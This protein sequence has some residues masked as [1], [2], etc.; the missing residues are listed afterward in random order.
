MEGA[1]I[2]LA[3]LW[4]AYFAIHSLLASNK[5]KALVAG[6]MPLLYP[7]YRILYN[8]FALAGFV[9]IFAFQRTLPKAVILQTQSWTLCVGALIMFAGFLIGSAAFMTFDKKEFLGLKQ[10]RKK[11][12][13]KEKLITTGLYSLVRHPLYFSMI[14]ILIGYL[15]YAFNLA[16]L[17][18]VATAMVYLIVGTKLEEQKLIQTFGKDYRIYKSKVKML[19]PFLF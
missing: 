11:K 16:N 7:Y 13:K 10:L 2:M 12:G 5:V 4:I 1:H 6:R 8:L 14:L 9:G 19:I 18:F 15:M 17:I 3:V